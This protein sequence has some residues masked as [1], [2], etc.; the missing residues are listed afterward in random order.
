MQQESEV[1]EEALDD[2]LCNHLTQ[3]AQCEAYLGIL[4]LPTL[5][6]KVG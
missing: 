1:D 3:K 6:S 5:W 2:H 4:D